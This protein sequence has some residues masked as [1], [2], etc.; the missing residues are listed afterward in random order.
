MAR[1]PRDRASE[2]EF[3]D[4]HIA[5]D[6]PDRFHPPA[7]PLV[8]SLHRAFSHLV[9]RRP[10]LDVQRVIDDVFIVQI[11]LAAAKLLE[12][13]FGGVRCV[14]PRSPRNADRFESVQFLSRARSLEPLRHRRTIVRRSFQ[15]TRAPAG[16]HAVAST[17]TI[18]SRIF[19]RFVGEPS[20]IPSL[21]RL[22]VHSRVKIRPR[23]LPASHPERLQAGPLRPVPSGVRPI[24]F[25]R[26]DRKKSDACPS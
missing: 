2:D 3:S 15:R 4:R 8:S 24:C 6:A 11:S 22:T 13:S 26:A 21:N 18:R 1:K 7:R 16:K 17:T 23:I 25:P 20:L 19:P 10:H 5:P 9:Q 12:A 14:S